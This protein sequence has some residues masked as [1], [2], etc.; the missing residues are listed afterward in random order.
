MTAVC[1][2]CA[3]DLAGTLSVVATVGK[4]ITFCRQFAGRADVAQLAEHFT[5]NEGVGGSSPPVG[6]KKGPQSGSFPF[7]DPTSPSV[8]CPGYVARRTD[9]RRHA[10][11]AE[12]PRLPRRA[13][14]R[15]AV[16]R[17]V[18]AAGWLPGAAPS[19]A[20]VDRER[21]RPPAGYFTKRT[22]EAWLLDVLHQARHGTLP[23]Q[24]RT[25]VTFADAAAEWLRYIE[26][27][28]ERKPSTVAGYWALV[29]SQLLPAFG[30]EPI[31]SI[32]TPMIEH[33]LAGSSGRQARARSR[34]SCCTAS[35][36]ARASS[37]T[38]RARRPR[39]R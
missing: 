28:R 3:P 7:R 10:R 32:T 12:R 19:R 24:V 27:D 15:P 20:R 4:N 1:T 25:G 26:H 5:R 18:P 21:G 17:Q 36:S 39:C 37:S 11:R 9:D 22:A 29:R 35:S 30:D 13:Q 31:E 38:P 23:G 6:F 16:V 33:W 14:A 2:G 34:S 8:M